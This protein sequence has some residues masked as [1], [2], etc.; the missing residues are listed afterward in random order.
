MGVEAGEL[1]ACCGHGVNA[2]GAVVGRA[3]GPDVSVPHVVDK[4]DHEIRSI[5]R[6]AA[7]RCGGAAAR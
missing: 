5:T 2:R 3:E 1:H 4:D 7:G 6:F